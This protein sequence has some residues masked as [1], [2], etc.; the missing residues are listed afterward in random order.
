[1]PELQSTEPKTADH[2]E[3]GARRAQPLTLFPTLE[4]LADVMALAEARL[5]ITDSN[6][7]HALLACYHNTLLRQVDL[8]RVQP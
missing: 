7:L 5:P 8:C 6:T 4:S 3:A 1:M 2:P